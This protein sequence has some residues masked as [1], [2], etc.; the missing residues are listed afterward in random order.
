MSKK[1]EPST[2]SSQ[3]WS[4]SMAPNFGAS[5]SYCHALAEQ[6]T[7]FKRCKNCKIV[8]YCSRLCQKKD[9][10]QHKGVCARGDPIHELEQ[11]QAVDA[12]VKQATRMWSSTVPLQPVEGED[13]IRQV[14]VVHDIATAE[15]LTALFAQGL[16]LETKP[17]FQQVIAAKP[18][19]GECQR[20]QCHEAGTMKCARC[21]MVG[22]CSRKC[23][24]LDWKS[25]HKHVCQEAEED[26]DEA[27]EP[28]VDEDSK[29]ESASKSKLH[30]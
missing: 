13:V 16:P 29:D 11:K 17:A 28:D 9:R 20:L 10:A 26:S 18:I 7:S 22:Y 19:E 21:K 2:L 6:G 24:K 23:Q 3:S 15:H 5:C 1:R 30:S 12:Q 25:I 4:V 14:H 27:S 8:H